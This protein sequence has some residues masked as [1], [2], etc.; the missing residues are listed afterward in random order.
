MAVYEIPR[1]TEL[2]NQRVQKGHTQKEKK[3]RKR[4]LKGCD[5]CR[6]V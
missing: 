2:G 6:K 5:C 4:L 1:Q 3:L